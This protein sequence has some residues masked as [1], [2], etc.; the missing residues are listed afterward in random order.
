MTKKPA[1]KTS[2]TKASDSTIDIDDESLT[3]GDALEELES[4]LDELEVTD[5]DV[6]HLAE[7]VARGV[8]LVRFCRA[9]L[10]VVTEDVQSVVSELL[11]PDPHSETDDAYDGTTYS[12]TAYRD[13]ESNNDSD[14]EEPNDSD[15]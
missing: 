11:A 2:T 8:K 3:Y 4:L 10:D 14:H 1:T 7:R 9:R 15:E 12:G 5:V 6:D 13:S